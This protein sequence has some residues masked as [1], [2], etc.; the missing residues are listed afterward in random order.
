MKVVIIGSGNV[1][2]V[3]GKKMKRAGVEILQVA[4]RNEKEGA[5]LAEKLE[6][7]FTNNLLEV[8]RGGDLYLI[9]VP[10]TVIS[11]TAKLLRLEGKMIVH[12]AGSV[13]K[14]VLIN[15]GL[16]NCSLGVIYPLQ[17]LKKQNE[18]IPAVPVL[19]DGDSDSTIQSLQKF[20]SI[21]AEEVAIAN[22]E[23]RLKM[24][25][26]AVF[27]NNFSNYMFTMAERICDKE[28]LN[29]SMLLPLILETTNRL[30]AFKPSEVQTGPA[31]RQDHQ[32]IEKHLRLLNNY[33]S[34]KHLYKEI[35][36][37]IL[38]EQAAE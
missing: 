14:N 8:D 19:I 13:L 32:T 21:W 10:D 33:P 28:Q 2:T 4:A 35:T 5:S 29:F 34:L 12:T 9:A 6:A 16:I 11:A 3:V 37:S 20:S 1:A 25:L 31:V 30:Q 23:Q 7:S 36:S 18:I 17:S 24:H 38:E 15:E 22:D 26:A 27:A